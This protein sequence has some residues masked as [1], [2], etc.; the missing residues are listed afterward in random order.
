MKFLKS[1]SILFISF[2][3]LNTAPSL[4]A[5][6]INI[7]I[8]TLNGKT[9]TLEVELEYTI[10]SVKKQIQAK[11]GIPPDKQTLIYSGKA[12]DEDSVLADYKIEPESQL[13][14][15]FPSKRD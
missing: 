10:H 3:F 8:K 13:F 7:T 1:P 5:K 4:Y 6:P 11:E 15:I 12:L 9:I 14:L 2:L